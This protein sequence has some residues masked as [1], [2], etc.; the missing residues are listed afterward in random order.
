MILLMSVGAAMTL[1]LSWVHGPYELGMENV[2]IVGLSEQHLA[3][4][5]KVP[6]DKQHYH[7][8]FGWSQLC[9]WFQQQSWAA[10][11]LSLS[12]HPTYSTDDM[13]P[14]RESDEWGVTFPEPLWS[15]AHCSYNPEDLVQ[16]SWPGQCFVCVCVCLRS[17]DQVQES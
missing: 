5:C 2:V 9:G 17:Q 8:L 7:D 11:S 3:Y 13:G 14:C 16:I 12:Q 6:L 4:V 15:C 10:S 1:W